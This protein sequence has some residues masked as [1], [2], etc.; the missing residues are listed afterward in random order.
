MSKNKAFT[1]A[2]ILITLGIIGV[3]SAITMS[4]LTKNINK[5]IAKNQFKKAYSTISNALNL[6]V[7]EYGEN[8]KCY[9]VAN[10]GDR[11]NSDCTDFFVNTFFKKLDT[12]KICINNAFQNGCMPD[13]SAVD[14]PNKSGCSGF[15][16]NTIKTNAPTALLKNGMVI[17]LYNDSIRKQPVIAVDINGFKKPNKGGIDVFSFQITKTGNNIPRIN[18]NNMN[19]CMPVADEKYFKNIIDIYK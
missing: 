2:E 1:L 16:S 15:Y 13:Y 18:A 5:H 7:Q 17:F 10:S 12:S 14:F 6:S 9:Y 8:L 4:V 11:E 3:V 19:F